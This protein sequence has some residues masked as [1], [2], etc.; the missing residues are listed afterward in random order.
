MYWIYRLFN[1]ICSIG[2]LYRCY[3]SKKFRHLT[4]SNYVDTTD[5]PTS[6]VTWNIQGLFIYMNKTKTKNILNQ[7]LIMKQTD[8]FCLQEVF[9]DHLKEEI[10]YT[11]KDS[12]PY[13]LLGNTYK[14]Y[15]IG[16]DSGLLILSKY[17]IKFVKESVLDEY[18]F[19]DRMANKSILYF[20]VGCLNIMTTH[21]QSDFMFYNK[22]ISDK[23]LK[24]LKDKVPFNKFI[25]TGDL[26]NENAEKQLSIRKNNIINTWWDGYKTKKI[27]DYILPYNY[28][29]I[30]TVFSTS[31]PNIDITNISDHYPLKCQLV[32]K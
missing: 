6:I 20:K 13:Y 30:L 15:I 4:N 22:D 10:I 19:P 18:F 24:L 2:R 5:K 21:L 11:M 29:D 31:V 8:I 25:I 3:K 17:P 27:L 23:Q 9:E 32:Y 12:H 28:E 26:N 14:R 7:L 16:E 1:C